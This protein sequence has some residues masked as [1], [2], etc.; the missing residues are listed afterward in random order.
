MKKERTPYHGKPPNLWGDQPRWCDLRAL[1]KSTETGLVRAKQRATQ[2]ISTTI[3]G[4]HSLTC[5]EGGWALRLG[6]WRSVPGK[7]LGLAVWRQP[8]GL[9]SLVPQAGERNA[10]A[11]G[12][13]K[14]VWACRRSKTIG[15]G[16]R[17]G[18][19]L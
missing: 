13:L 7:G 6:L 10:T 11:E 15:K 18:R 9:G 17:R 19:L 12:T 8:E 3:P 1:E 2:T 14:E 16:R 4:H 5:L